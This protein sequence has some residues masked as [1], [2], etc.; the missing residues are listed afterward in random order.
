MMA[1]IKPFEE[2]ASEYD[3]WFEDNRLIYESELRAIN[4]QLPKIGEG[5]EVGVGSGR[6]AG[7]LGIRIGVD[8]SQKMRELARDRGIEAIDGTAEKLPFKDSRFGFVLMVTTICFLDNVEE[9]FKEAYRVLKPGGHLIIGFIDKNSHVGISYQQHRN[10]STFYAIATFYSC[11]E[12]ISL[13]K[14]SRFKNLN[15]KQT[16]LGD[17]LKTNKI[18]RVKDGYGEG[19][20]I[21][22]KASKQIA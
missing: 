1:K 8:P 19:S 16:I 22:V 10:E 15:F 2:H 14:K 3:A 5:L 18:G 20:F 4:E 12:I 13:L 21:V 11:D 6:F 17:P 7:P 9:A